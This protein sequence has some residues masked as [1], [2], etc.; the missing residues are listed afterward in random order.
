VSPEADDAPDVVVPDDASALEEPV[1]VALLL[2][3]VVAA[4]PLA[5]VCT[6]AGVRAVA[7][8]SIAVLEDPTTGPQAAAAVSRL[9]KGT[10]LVLCERRAGAIA[11]SRWSLGSHDEDLAPGLLLDSGP[12]VLEDLLLG[13]VVP[14]DLDGVVSSADISRF[15]A[16]RV[17]TK[18]A[19]QARKG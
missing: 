7:I 2:T 8:G 11:A 16:V 4:E 18:I 5:A 19:R 9:L 1:T 13:D 10:D 14:G 6:L 17:L 12:A 15:K 3:Q